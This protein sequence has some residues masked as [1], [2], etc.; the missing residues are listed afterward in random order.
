MP[1]GNVAENAYGAAIYTIL[2]KGFCF[3]SAACASVVVLSFTLQ[4]GFVVWLDDFLPRSEGGPFSKRDLF[5]YDVDVR[6]GRKGC[7]ES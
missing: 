1:L 3:E 2:M 4:F 6:G 5:G 7:R